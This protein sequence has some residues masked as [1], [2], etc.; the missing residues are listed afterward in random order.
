MEDSALQASLAAVAEARLAV[1]R[2]QEITAALEV[3]LEVTEASHQRM[4]M[5]EAGAAIVDRLAA[6]LLHT[7]EVAEVVA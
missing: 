4:D 2:H 6:T 7:A 5:P 1:L 3:L